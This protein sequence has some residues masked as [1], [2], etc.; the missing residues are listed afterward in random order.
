[1][2]SLSLE[3]LA[4]VLIGVTLAVVWIHGSVNHFV[5]C[6]QDCGETFVAQQSVVN[7][8]LYGAK[9]WLLQDHSTIQ[10]PDRHPFIYTHNVH[11]GTLLFPLLDAIG[12]SSFW[13]K[14]LFTLLGFG[15]GLFYVF[16]TVRY[17]TRSSF[18]AFCVLILFCTDYG[19]VFLFGLNTLRAWHWLALFGMVFHAL[20]I[21]ADGEVRRTSDI[22]AITGFTV[23]SFGIGYEFLAISLGVTLFVAIL[24]AGSIR[25]P[26]ICLGWLLGSVI[27]V[28]AFR[29]AQ[30]I[31]V[32]GTEFWSMDV[33]YSAVIKVTSL[34]KYFHIP[35]LPDIDA[36]YLAHG[37]LRPFAAAAPIDQVL[38]GLEQHLFE[39]TLP[40]VGAGATASWFMGLVLSVVIIVVWVVRRG[41]DVMGR[42]GVSVS[43]S[44]LPSDAVTGPR[45]WV[46]ATSTARFYGALSL[47]TAASLSAFGSVAVSIYLKHQ[48]PLMA[49]VVLIPKGIFIALGLLLAVAR[50]RRAGLRMMGAVLAILLIVDHAAT[51]HQNVLALRP[52][53]VGWIPEVAKRPD[54]TFA[55]S[56]I[57]S[58]VAGFTRNWAIGIQPGLER[59]VLDR[60]N[61]HEPLF[62]QGDLLEVNILHEEDIQKYHMLQPDYWLYY[63]TDQKAEVQATLPACSR[64][65]ARRLYDDLTV[66]R[67]VPQLKRVDFADRPSMR[68]ATGELNVTGRAVEG[69]E[70]SAGDK[71]IARVGLRCDTAAFAAALP[72]FTTS[73]PEQLTMTAFDYAG[74]RYSLG[75]MKAASREQPDNLP[76]SLPQ[77]QPSAETMIELNRALPIAAQGPG[78]VLFDL[79]SLW[80]RS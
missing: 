75:T 14:Q 34:A 35:R 16:L 69:V 55:V 21:V 56:W 19:Q 77:H 59:R 80:K 76:A 73:A 29:Q 25:R 47:G 7:Y 37:V 22:A 71:V 4:L 64:S 74:R 50:S 44:S 61:R 33:F 15:A 51:Q 63:A 32:F 65:Y 3:R 43:A 8:H 79:R 5:P 54:A 41:L 53:P 2:P 11:L 20:R 18:A 40:S 12:I 24:C 36:F 58:S 38:L 30:V 39:I 23:L 1:M 45:G 48:M 46:D 9:Y 10:D 27:L 13:A 60:A 66:P 52:T 6:A 42:A 31:A 78:F 67:A 68:M 72:G 57:P 49:A 26:V 62:T 70:F 28:F 17:V